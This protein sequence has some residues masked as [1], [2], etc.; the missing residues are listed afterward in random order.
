MG[1]KKNWIKRSL[2]LFLTAALIGNG[3]GSTMLTVLAEEDTSETAVTEDNSENQA[4]ALPETTILPEDEEDADNTQENTGED[5]WFT[6]E[7]A[8]SAEDKD[9]PDNEELLAGY[10]DQLFFGD[11]NGGISLFGEFGTIKLTGDDLAIYNMLKANIQQVASGEAPIAAH[12]S[13]STIFKFDSARMV[14]NLTDAEISQSK[15]DE[16]AFGK[17]VLKKMGERMDTILDYL[18]MD[19]PLDFYWFDK[20]KGMGCGYSYSVSEE[21]KT[22]SLNIEEVSFA[23]SSD[24]WAI[25]TG[26][27][28][29]E[30]LYLVDTGRISRVKTAVDKAKE[31]VEKYKDASDYEKLT[32][33]CSEICAL[34][35][36]ADYAAE[37]KNT[38]YGNPW[39]LISV[40]DGDEATRVV[41]E[42][43]AKAFQYL[44][45]LS[46]FSGD[47]VCYT[48]TGTMEGGTGRGGHMWNIVTLGGKNYLV[49]VTNCD[50]GTIGAPDQ[51]FLAGTSGSAAGGYTFLSSVKYTYDED[52]EAL[53]GR[54]ILTLADENYVPESSLNLTVPAV[55]VTYG[56]TVAA[57]V[58]SGG[59]AFAGETR[60]EGTFA[61]PEDL[62]SYGAAGTKSLRA[63]FTPSHA[64]SGYGPQIAVV[65]VTVNPK[66]ITVTANPAKKIYGE[67]DP[68]LTYSVQSGAL[69]GDDRLSGTLA[70][71]AGEDVKADGYSISQGTLTDMN[72]PNYRIQ[73]TG[74]SF[75]IE[76][77]EIKSVVMA[78]NQ[79]IL[80]G[81]GKF[82]E[83]AFT[84]VK[85]EQVEGSVTYGYLEET[86]LSYQQLTDRLKGLQTG[87]TGRISYVF[88]PSSLNY[89]NKEGFIQ[90]TIKDIEF[91]VG[92]EPAAVSNA[93]TVKQQPV[94]GDSWS[95]IVKIKTITARAGDESDSSA[96]HFTIDVSG[97]PEAGEHTFKVLYN[98]TL[99]GKTYENTEVLSGTV[100]VGK[101]AV[102]VNPGTYKISKVY[103]G[104]TEPGTATGALEILGRVSTDTESEFS[105]TAEPVP[106]E[107][108]DAGKQTVMDITFQFSG[109]KAGNYTASSYVVTVPCE[110]T[111]KQITPEVTVASGSVYT[112]NALTPAITVTDA[113]TVLTDMDYDVLYSNNIDAG[114]GKVTVSP[115]AGGNYQWTAVQ[116][117]FTIDKADYSGKTEDMK[118]TRYGN[119]DQYNLASLL[120]AGAKLGEISLVDENGIFTEAPSLSG[121][122]LS[123]KVDSDTEKIGKTAVITVPV[124]ETANYNPFEIEV[125]VSISDKLVQTD[126]KFAA[127]DVKRTYGDADFTIA[128]QNAAIGSIVTYMSSDPGIVQVDAG[129]RVHILRKGSVTITA[130]ASE[131]DDYAGKSVTCTLTVAPKA[132]TWDVSGMYAVDKQ[133]EV[134]DNRA[135]LYGALKV[136]GILPGDSAKAVFDCPVSML[137]GIYADTKP[138]QQ[139]VT[140]SWSG[141]QVLLEGE[142]AG[143][144]TMPSVLPEITGRINAVSELN[145]VP[146][147]TETVKYKLEVEEGISQIPDTLKNIESLNTPAKIEDKMKSEVEKNFSSADSQKIVE[148]YDVV[149]MVNK[150]NGGWEVATPDNF[151]ENGL[152]VT[153]PYPEGTGKDTH[154]FVVS[155]MFTISMNGHQPGETENP[156][157]TKTDAGVQFKVTSLSPIGVGAEQ[158]PAATSGSGTGGSNN[159]ASGTRAANTG[160]ENTIMLYVLLL[161]LGVAGVGFSMK[162]KMVR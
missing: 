29:N 23:V 130:S 94:Y 52:Q 87:D 6:G 82:A 34:T 114:I 157:V 14:L 144:Y 142:A 132:L 122:I 109:T 98:G 38:P 151:P 43:Y 5:K 140:L 153:L 84:G 67:E 103:D 93:V 147:S 2:V 27:E 110:I 135:T 32:A 15:T 127:A 8:I 28:E 51:L 121:T 148:V 26:I 107:S 90:F 61:W 124:T 59:T 75:M 50:T 79:N 83:P 139:K 54:D 68:E 4:P 141:N 16:N 69:V 119:V 102:T 58:L 7:G 21:S 154:N 160:D 80:Q 162:R 138:G 156:A 136:S 97:V 33:Y 137:S 123:Y 145:N 1:G 35:S 152:T 118:S 41:C 117:E 42:G 81:S 115:K 106:F 19:N 159:A 73:F 96:G 146:E 129:G 78:E 70:R 74:N 105:V 92:N 66:V 55:E 128:A 85:D 89:S 46:S 120:P 30:R 149:L 49:D 91:V 133:G 125:T 36:Y 71:Q 104:T 10:I 76:A 155:H 47:T 24:F 3:A 150:D 17:T 112:G 100:N 31:I 62:L 86:G 158:I 11:L 57:S 40:F 53:F 45:D 18:L 113:E 22:C 64:D 126:F 20:T 108:A 111:P 116:K 12:S 143:N 95:D 48:V 101:K 37:D 13:M 56:D 131:T 63:V 44:C 25:E 72:N 99:G 77:A 161:L 9:L 60:I 88:Q 39:Q 65:Q 134:K